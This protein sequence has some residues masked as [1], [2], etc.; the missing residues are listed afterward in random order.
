MF[1]G[2]AFAMRCAARRPRTWHRAGR[3][4]ASTRAAA[5]L[6]ALLACAWTSTGRSSQ[7]ADPPAAATVDY[8]R[9]IQPLLAR[10]CYACHGPDKN[11]GGLRLHDPQAALA[12]LDSG[13][14]AIVPGK[15]EQSALLA[16]VTAQDHALRMPPE[17][18]PLEAQ[19]IERLRRWIA[20][21]ARFEVHWA[22]R[23]LQR[24][25]PPQVSDRA[26]VRNPIDAFVLHELEQ[27]GLS[28]A[29]PADAV[30]LVRRVYYD[31]IGLPPTPEEIDAF[32]AESSAAGADGEAV[33]ARLVDRLLDSPHYGEKWARHWLDLVRYAETNGYE[34]DNPKENAWKYR[35]YVIRS[36]NDDKPY[37]RFILEQLAGDELP[38]ATPETI[39]ATGFYRLGLWDDEPVDRQQAFYDGLDDVLSTMSQAFL[40]MTLGCARC[41]DH[42]IDPVPQRDYYRLLAFVHNL[43]HGNTQAVVATAE[44]LEQHAARLRAHREQL[45]ALDATVASFEDRIYAT[46]SNPEKEDA[47]DA[48][49]REQLLAQRRAQVLSPSELK[50]Y[51]AALDRRQR[52][53]SR[54]V[55][56]PP[57]ALA[58]EENGPRPPETKILL[59][60]NP[61]APGPTVEPGFP[62]VVAGR[63]A[64]LVEI[65]APK[66]GASS[67]RRLALA[68]WI[69]RADN[70]LTARVMA[71]RVWQFHFG[72]GIV[73][74]SSDFGYGG[75]PP[76][77]PALLDYLACELI[78]GGWRL[79]GLHRQILLSSAYRMSSQAS[80]AGLQRDP[81]NRLFWRFN[82]R[83]LTAE[84]IRDSVL[85]VSGNLNL[86]MHG[87]SIY[88]PLPQEVLATASRP[89]AAW[90]R[91][92]PDE[93]ARRSIYIHVKRSLRPP[94]LTN[95]DAPDT[96]VPCAVRFATTVPTQALGMLNSRFMNE[97][98]GVFAA[99]L[100]REAPGDRAAQV[101]RALRLTIGR[102]PS[103]QEVDE[104]VRFIE[105]LVREERLDATEALRLYC[106][107]L[108]NAN[109]FVYLD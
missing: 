68:R 69:A 54:A 52:L 28:P 74:S 77:H 57:Q 10:R 108:L 47:K 64:S 39:I 86:A 19:Q 67:G 63:M 32:V 91:S 79:K 22:Y 35:D 103:P 80:P 100:Q 87:P 8:L 49:V 56:P 95:F 42:K 82:L 76:T 46:L 88:P 105:S 53:K 26:W 27:Q 16:R 98:A 51:L 6:V 83:R 65:D 45:S 41:H 24:P 21:G 62:E 99:R 37:D 71:N 3:H 60:G 109:E 33:Y 20:A 90:G 104:D 18:P 29:P 9:D 5:V 11:E 12:E 85:A 23:P 70:P 34:R 75:T 61:H 106:L 43:K 72:R 93:A 38:D 40:A 89:D 92:P 73:E 97:Q 17:G 102:V 59:R 4:N 36:F 1:Y 94:M 48:R 31:L 81:T 44:E 78:E 58:A 15:P 50:E 2:S 107:L 25:Q 55:P 13:N 66:R 14:H 7:A 84:E 96:D 30:T 101:R